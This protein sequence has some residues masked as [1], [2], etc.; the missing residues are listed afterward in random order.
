MSLNKGDTIQHLLLK[1]GIVLPNIRNK[2]LINF[3]KL[4]KNA[5]RPIITH[6]TTDIT[7][8][9]QD[10]QKDLAL[11]LLFIVEDIKE[12]KLQLNVGHVKKIENI[13]RNYIQRSYLLGTAYV[14][15]I[16]NDK[17][18]ITDTD[19]RIIKFLSEYYSQIYVNNI[20]KVLNDPKLLLVNPE[21]VILD[22]EENKLNGGNVFNNISDA[23]GATFQSLQ[24]STI[25]K[26]ITLFEQY[27][28]DDFD[29]QIINNEEGEKKQK[30]EFNWATSKDERVCKICVELATKSWDIHDYQQ[31]PLIPHGSHP[32]CVCRI[33]LRLVSN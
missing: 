24:I 17:G 31:I 22:I 14:N 6:D 9:A 33:L 4:D 25:V 23:I 11:E 5:L 8:A 2:K 15:N 10:L 12:N 32:R 7:I 29:S 21:R 27:S 1:I 13:F 26:T 19:L 3:E 16:F 20:D 30:I 18:F 28:I